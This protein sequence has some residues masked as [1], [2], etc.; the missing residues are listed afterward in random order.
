[1]IATALPALLVALAGAP[2]GRVLEGIYRAEEG[3]LPGWQDYGW[4]PR[5]LERGG[6]VQLD[7]SNRGGWIVGHAELHQPFAALVL[8]LKAPAGEAAFLE[9][10][11]DSQRSRV[12][13]RVALGSYAGSNLADGWTQITVPFAALNPRGV[14]FDRVMLRAARTRPAETVLLDDLALVAGSSLPS[15]AAAVSAS[16]RDLISIDCGARS[17][18]IS[19]MVYGLAYNFTEAAHDRWVWELNP[20]ARRWGGNPASRYNWRLGNAWNT[21]S[22]WYFR[23]VN[24]TGSATYSWRDFLEE[25]R[26]HATATALTV[27]MLGWVAKDTSSYS[28]PVRVFGAQQSTAPELRDAGNGVSPGGKNLPARSP[29]RTSV[30]APPSFIGEWISA[31]PKQP[32]R[33]A[34]DLVFLDNEPTL[35]SSTHRDVHPERVS[36]D[37]L[38]AKT[39]AYGTAVRE[40]DPR[41]VIAGFSA[42]GWPALFVSGVDA[43]VPLRLRTD[44]RQ[45]GGQDLLPWFLAGVRDHERQAGKKILDVL[46]VHFYPQGKDLGI[47]KT[48]GTDPETAARR[49]RATRAL[50]DPSYRDESWIG[51]PVRLIPRLREAIAAGRPGLGISIGEYNFGA[52]EHLSGGLAVAEALG[53]FGSLGVDAAFYWTYPPHGSAAYWAFRAFRNYDGR[54]SHFL[55]ISLPARSAAPALSV[56]AARDP[57]TRALTVVLL[58]LDPREAR[59][60]QIRLSRCGTAQPGRSFQ[61]AGGAEGLSPEALPAADGQPALRR[62]PAWSITVL[63]VPLQR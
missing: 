50:W 40:A 20:G 4:A 41:A 27:P 9:V 14:P 61:Y 28:F 34:V 44:R 23:N 25:Q 24:Y 43:D 39:V 45:H 15:P 31:L 29:D 12:F 18:S 2:E 49:I 53:R 16:R 58:N 26:A 62:L 10:Q 55:D 46:D 42:W 22:D 56:F 47:G 6:P 54:G 36:Y 3:L 8:R 35:W 59:D 17:H 5:R 7:L 13:P 38:L 30:A 63:E 21:A 19:P 52:E 60:A 11:L 1:M 32:G 48:G 37:E 33:P 51:E 57:A